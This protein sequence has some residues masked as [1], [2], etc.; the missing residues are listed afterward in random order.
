MHPI[1]TAFTHTTATDTIITTSTATTATK[2]KA[3]EI[4]STASTITATKAE[5]IKTKILKISELYRNK[6]EYT[7]PAQVVKRTYQK[8][9]SSV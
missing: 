9:F 6:L 3:P 2:A 4:N 7:M 1:A 5:G 8:F